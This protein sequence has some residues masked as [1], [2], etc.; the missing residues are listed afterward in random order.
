MVRAA[1]EVAILVIVLCVRWA[2]GPL[3]LPNFPWTKGSGGGG[4]GE[5]ECYVAIGVSQ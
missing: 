4:W 1:V 5:G 2:A 3:N